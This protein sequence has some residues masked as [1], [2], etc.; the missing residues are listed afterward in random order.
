MYMYVCSTVHDSGNL[1]LYMIAYIYDYMYSN[2]ILVVEFLAW[3]SKLA[4]FYRKNECTKSI[5]CILKTDIAWG[6]QNPGIISEYELPLNLKSIIYLL[7]VDDIIS[8]SFSKH[9]Q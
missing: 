8:N 9:F 4:W 7:K 3:V 6:L 2:I 1:R 5:F